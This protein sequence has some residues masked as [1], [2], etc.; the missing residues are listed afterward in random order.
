MKKLFILIIALGLV[1]VAAGFI[2]PK[3]IN[4]FFFEQKTTSSPAVSNEVIKNKV[5]LLIDCGSA[6]PQTT[7]INFLPEMSAFDLLKKGTEELNLTIKT[8]NYDMGVF[9]EAIGEKENGQ[10]NKYWFYYVNGE[11]PMVAADKKLIK[12]GDKV[13]FKFEKS[14]F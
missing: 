11:M 5:L 13:E 8:K 4:Q 1:V 9:I 10:D 2:F 14:P 6:A 12:P 3:E 7:E